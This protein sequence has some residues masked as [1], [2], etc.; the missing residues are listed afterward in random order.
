MFA[1]FMVFMLRWAHLLHFVNQIIPEWNTDFQKL[2]YSFNSI[3]KPRL[4]VYQLH[5]KWSQPFMCHTFSFIHI[6]VPSGKYLM[7]TS[8]NIEL[9]TDCTICEKTNYRTWM[10]W[11]S[12]QWSSVS[13][14]R[15]LK[16]NKIF[17]PCIFLKHIT[18][19]TKTNG[20]INDID[21]IHSDWRF[22]KRKKWKFIK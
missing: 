18:P 10:L 21:I 13:I 3:T 2:N 7:T 6:F 11:F 4:V 20:S 22:N 5:R 14:K 19:P 1:I 12:R 17:S 16:K 9:H 8:N 15:R